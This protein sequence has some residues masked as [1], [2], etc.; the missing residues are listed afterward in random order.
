MTLL[1]LLILI[2]IGITLYL[3]YWDWDWYFCW[4]EDA[5]SLIRKLC[6]VILFVH[7][8]LMIDSSNSYNNIRIEN[9]ELRKQYELFKI[10]EK[11]IDLGI[12]QQKIIDHNIDLEK[13]K[14]Y[15]STW[16]FGCYYDDRIIEI[17]TIQ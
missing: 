13:A 9:T 1:I 12:M 3:I 5:L 7:S 10:N 6:V 15:N 4:D 11:S 14:Y 16:Y 17:K 8:L 2:I